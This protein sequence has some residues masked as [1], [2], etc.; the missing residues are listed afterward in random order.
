MLEVRVRRQSPTPTARSCSTWT[1]SR[2]TTWSIHRTRC[3]S[4]GYCSAA[5]APRAVCGGGGEQ[6]D[7]PRWRRAAAPTTSSCRSPTRRCTASSAKLVGAE[8]RPPLPQ[9]GDA[10]RDLGRR[11]GTGRRPSATPRSRRCASSSA[12]GRYP[13]ATS[14]RRGDGRSRGRCAATDGGA[15]RRH[16]RVPRAVRAPGRR[17]ARGLRPRRARAAPAANP[18]ALEVE[19]VDDEVAPSSVVASS[20]ARRART[21][22]TRRRAAGC[23]GEW[24]DTPFTTVVGGLGTR[25]QLVKGDAQ[26]LGRGGARSG[27]EAARVPVVRQRHARAAAALVLRATWPVPCFCAA[28]RS[29]TIPTTAGD[30]PGRRRRRPPRRADLARR[31]RDVPVARGRHEHAERGAVCGG[32]ADGPDVRRRLRSS[33]GVRWRCRRGLRG[34]ARRRW[35]RPTARKRQAAPAATRT[36]PHRQSWGVTPPRAPRRRR[37]RRPRWP[38]PT[39]LTTLRRSGAGRS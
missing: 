28:G 25:R 22:S 21:C 19:D 11:G 36:R 16:G 23:G 29:A 7:R 38:R 1:S 18:Q 13:A 31:R 14:V 2:A 24:D 37:R 5:G 30:G 15:P 3:C 26:R 39:A 33:Q 20:R 27:A 32:V 35:A 9:E 34:T 4:P 6:R 17:A 10:D 12:G 8:L